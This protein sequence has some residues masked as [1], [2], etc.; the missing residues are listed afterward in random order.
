MHL[1]ISLVNK[2]LYQTKKKILKNNFVNIFIFSNTHTCKKKKKIHTK[3]KKKK[4]PYFNRYITTS[5]QEDVSPLTLSVDN[6]EI[7]HVNTRVRLGLSVQYYTKTRP[8]KSSLQLISSPLPWTHY[9]PSTYTV[10]F[11][12]LIISPFCVIQSALLLLFA[13]LQRVG[14]PVEPL[15]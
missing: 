9:T 5:Y 13:V 7:K 1:P 6:G 4:S 10:C 2:S 15:V 11:C 3:H 14:E 12:L 8:E